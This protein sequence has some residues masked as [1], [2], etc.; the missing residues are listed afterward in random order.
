MKGDTRITGES[1]ERARWWEAHSRS[2]PITRFA[3]NEAQSI[4]EIH[5]FADLGGNM[6]TVIQR[7]NSTELGREVT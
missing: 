6:P 1:P 5:W 3:L 4:D 7:E 2:N